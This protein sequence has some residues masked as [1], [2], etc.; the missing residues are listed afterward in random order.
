MGGYLLQ[1]GFAIW[2]A[3][4]L[5]KRLWEPPGS[6]SFPRTALR[7]RCCRC[8]LAFLSALRLREHGRSLSFRE[9][10]QIRG[11]AGY[12]LDTC[13]C[14]QFKPPSAPGKAGALDYAGIDLTITA[15]PSTL[16]PGLVCLGMILAYSTAGSARKRSTSGYKSLLSCV[17][18]AKS[19]IGRRVA[20][21]CCRF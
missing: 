1:E 14:N 12:V 4:E 17:R 3:G 6:W 18:L 16:V 19:L 11:G 13:T 9:K 5:R 8:P 20:L 2:K 7:A 10:C 21:C 15:P